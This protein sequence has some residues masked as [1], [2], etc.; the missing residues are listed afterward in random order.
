MLTLHH[1]DTSMIK[2]HNLPRP[3]YDETFTSWVSR[4]GSNRHIHMSSLLNIRVTPDVIG[5]CV[6]YEDPD[7]DFKSPYFLSAS[8]LIGVD[9]AQL[10]SAFSPKTNWLL[11]WHQRKYYCPECLIDDVRR[12]RNP[13][14]R[15][16]WCYAYSSHCYLH[17][18]LLIELPGQLSANKAWD[19]FSD[20]VSMR[21]TYLHAD[22]KWSHSNPAALRFLLQQKA[23]RL[24]GASHSAYCKS[25][26]N[27]CNFIYFKV[28][29]QVFLQARTASTHAGAAR[30]LFSSGRVPINRSLAGYPDSL[31]IGALESSS[32]E[33]MC[34]VI[35]AG[36]VF[37]FYS[38]RDI[39]F[40]KSI[41]KYTGYYFPGDKYRLG[42]MAFEFVSR[43]DYLY[44]K[45]LFLKFPPTLNKKIKKFI[46][47]IDAS[48][49]D[50]FK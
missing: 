35:L 33:R 30:H 31:E 5:G 29:T 19:A 45:S 12:G 10:E 27:A 1:A 48:V 50:R 11:P 16:S 38:R 6:V 7:F 49:P 47:G 44:V 41:Y 14:W 18:K 32:H 42:R 46:D 22:S 43:N 21:N 36:L 4:C 20:Y 26:K 15:K 34:G 17:K 39:E 25:A 9:L 24:A 23:L 3:V 8:S 40:T 2:F 28:I 13:S 37:S